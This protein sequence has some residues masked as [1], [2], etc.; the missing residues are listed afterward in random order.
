MAVTGTLMYDATDFVP[1][2]VTEEQVRTLREWTWTGR[3][4][5]ATHERQG[6][7]ALT[8]FAGLDPDQIAF[9]VTLAKEL[10]TD[11]MEEL[12][13][14]W[15]WMRGGAPLALTVGT[16]NYGRYRWVIQ[17][18]EA[19]ITYTDREGNL[20]LCQ[21]KLELLEYLRR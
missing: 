8:E 2:L 19:E 5:W 15:R 9:T 11:P 3:A 10:G 4:R 12:E 6:T 18:H 20:L 17:G 7:D 21:E 14:I 1:F 13:R 16:H